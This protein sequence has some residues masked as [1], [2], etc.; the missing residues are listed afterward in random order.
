[1]SAVKKLLVLGGSMT[2]AWIAVDHEFYEDIGIYPKIICWHAQAWRHKVNA[3][4]DSI[5]DGVLHFHDVINNSVYFGGEN[6]HH[7]ALGSSEATALSD[8]SGIVFAQPTTERGFFFDLFRSHYFIYSGVTGERLLGDGGSSSNPMSKAVFYTW[9]LCRQ[10]HAGRFL[11][12]MAASHPDV[13]VFVAPE[14]LPRQDQN[15]YSIEFRRYYL[16]MEE[17]L[18]DLLRE[19]FNVLGCVQPVQTYDPAT[20]ATLGAFALPPPDPHHYSPEYVKAIV[21][22]G[23]F[24]EFLT[25]MR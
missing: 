15:S 9:W 6:R 13:P 4:P 10:F 2:T 23:E 24:R 17:V 22:T 14:V 12:E 7:P 16:I 3:S 11:E 8:V 18:I 20:L 5:R 25:R 21:G 19:K 1:V